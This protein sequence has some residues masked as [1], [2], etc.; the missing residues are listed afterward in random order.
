MSDL[1]TTLQKLPEYCYTVQPYDKRWVI[2]I[3]RGEP[4]YTDLS[5][6]KTPEEASAEAKRANMALGITPAQVE[7][8]TI[9]SAFGWD[10]PGADPDRYPDVT[11]YP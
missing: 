3:R 9:G 4:G 8:M 11:E 7:A 10:V 1:A 5:K 6:H 2:S